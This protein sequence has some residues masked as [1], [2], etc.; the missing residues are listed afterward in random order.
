MAVMSELRAFD[1]HRAVFD[2]YL[3]YTIFP[4][5]LELDISDMQPLSEALAEQKIPL[6]THLLSFEAKGNLYTFP[7]A[8]V[9]AYN[10]IHGQFHDGES[11][12]M[13]FC[14]ACNTGMVF[15]PILNGQMLRFS[16]RGSYDGLLMIWDQETGSY[17]QHITGECLYGPSAGKQLEI[18]TTTSQ[19]RASEAATV[20]LPVYLLTSTLTP[21][22]EKLSRA[23]ERMRANPETATEGIFKQIVSEDERRPR[24]ELGLGVWD[25]EMKRSSFYPL[26]LIYS[27]NN[28]LLTEFAGK[29]LLI[30]QKPEA[31]SPTAVFS[32]AAVAVW[33]GDVLRLDKGRTIRNDL[34]HG[35]DNQRVLPERPRQLLMRWYGFSLTFPNCDL[36]KAR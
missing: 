8:L 20:A 30:Y 4:A 33:E 1:V 9:L 22:Q 14:N 6:D 24:F 26:G 27:Q 2:D 19:M 15:N 11:W 16:R 7:M 31:L 10:V 17:W 23:M 12:M 21:I 13:T 32:D 3:D 18:I 35:S 25:T 29:P 5:R 34:C 36:P 28:A